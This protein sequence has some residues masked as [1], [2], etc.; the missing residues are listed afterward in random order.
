[1]VNTISADLWQLLID[2]VWLM[3]INATLR[4]PCC[5]QFN[6]NFSWCS[7]HY[8]LMSNTYDG[9]FWYS[10]I[11]IVVW[12]RDGFTELWYSMH[13]WQLIIWLVSCMVINATFNNI[14]IN[15]NNIL[16]DISIMSSSPSFCGIC[17][18][19]HISKSC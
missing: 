6:L 4:H 15:T 17:D 5:L 18:I 3:V 13:W 11:G 10:S 8:S 9:N 7:L 12:P 16:Q 1:M 19:R 2:L 14:S